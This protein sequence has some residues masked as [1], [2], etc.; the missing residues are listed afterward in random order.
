MS[1]KLKSIQEIKHQ[2]EIEFNVV[3]N[4][5]WTLCSHHNIHT[6]TNTPT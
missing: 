4:Y 6:Y 5:A 1:Y 2:R 3:G